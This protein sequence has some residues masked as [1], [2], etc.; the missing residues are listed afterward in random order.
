MRLFFGMFVP[1]GAP[2]SFAHFAKR[3]GAENACALGPERSCRAIVE[4]HRS[5]DRCDG[6]RFSRIVSFGENQ[7][8]ERIKIWRESKAG[9]NQ[10]LKIRIF[11]DLRVKIPTLSFQNAERRGVGHPL[12]LS[13]DLLAQAILLLSE[14]WSQ[15]S[16]E[17]FR[18][19]DLANFD[20][21][22]AVERAALEPLHR[23]IH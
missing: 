22:S 5:R 3:V 23:L 2:P 17:V 11:N 10:N 7:N 4:S 1:T 13:G 16:A 18:F 14:L 12:L 9:E 21:G 8:L 6:G 15:F 20:L 19:E